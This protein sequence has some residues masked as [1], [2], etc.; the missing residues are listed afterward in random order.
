M[1]YQMNQKSLTVG[2]FT[3][4]LRS[5]ERENRDFLFT[6]IIFVFTWLY[7]THTKKDIEKSN[8]LVVVVVVARTDQRLENDDKT[9]RHS[10]TQFTKLRWRTTTNGFFFFDFTSKY[11][12]FGEQQQKRSILAS[13]VDLDLEIRL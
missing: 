3:H 2:I 7:Y 13:K 4:I 5:I 11:T 1:N 8:L 10:K 9:H 6:P 12:Q